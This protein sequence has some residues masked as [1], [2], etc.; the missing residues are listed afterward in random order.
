MQDTF[1]Q[2]Y[3]EQYYKKFVEAQVR[4]DGRSFGE[5]RSASVAAGVISSA[6]SS[7]LARIGKTAVIAG[8]KLE[9]TVPEVQENDKG[10]FKVGLEF[11]KL[12]QAQDKQA[13]IIREKLQAVIV[14]EDFLDLTQLCIEKSQA[15]WEVVLD[16]YVLDNDGSVF[17]AALLAAVAAVKT[18][19]IPQVNFHGAGQIQLQEQSDKK[20]LQLGYNPIGLTCG[21]FQEKLVTD[22]NRHEESLMEQIVNLVTDENKNM[23]GI[24]MEGGSTMLDVRNFNYCIQLAEARYTEIAQELQRCLH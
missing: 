14:R 22:P 7:A 6:D 13:Q 5:S 2:L 4:P 19:K 12:C 21:L 15:A 11:S 24:F 8:I 16:A 17:D 1:S 3:P 10:H 23:I 18:L 20:S 9:L